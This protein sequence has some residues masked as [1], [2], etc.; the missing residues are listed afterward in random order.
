MASFSRSAFLMR[1]MP[2][3]QADPLTISHNYRN[4]VNFRSLG[5]ATSLLA[6]A[7]YW[8]LT[9]TA[10]FGHGTMQN[11]QDACYPSKTVWTT[12]VKP[13]VWLRAGRRARLI[14]R[15]RALYSGPPSPPDVIGTCKGTID[16]STKA[17]FRLLAIVDLLG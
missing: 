17:L 13:H 9:T 16:P 14:F 3:T 6:G 7:T 2:N 15:A 12:L 4:S 11:K 5:C 1:Q 8:A 10:M